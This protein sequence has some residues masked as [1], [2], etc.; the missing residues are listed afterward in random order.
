METKAHDILSLA[1][2]EGVRYFD[3]A[4][5]YGHGEAF[6]RKWYKL[7]APIGVAF[8]T[9]WGY[10]YVANWNPYHDGPHEIKEHSLEKLEEQWQASKNL[11]PA[12]TTYQIHSAT[13]ESKVLDNNRVLK[14]LLDIKA[15]YGYASVLPRADQSKT[16][17]LPKPWI[18][19]LMAKR[20][21]I[22]F[23]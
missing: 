13:L 15:G 22:V 9:K 20:C 18:S 3:T 19:K 10:T 12:L 23:R 14:R 1:Y 2:R 4:P 17:S 5:S 11:L 8:G 6:L 16:K 7:N 21:S